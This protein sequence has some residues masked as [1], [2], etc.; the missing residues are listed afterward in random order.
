RRTVT[1]L[2]GLAQLGCDCPCQGQINRLP[3]PDFAKIGRSM[4]NFVGTLLAQGDLAGARELQERALEPRAR[5]AQPLVS[6]TPATS[7]VRPAAPPHS[8]AI[9]RAASMSLTS[10]VRISS[11][12]YD[13]R[14]SMRPATPRYS[15]HVNTLPVVLV[16]CHTGSSNVA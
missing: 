8:L 12:G 4:R 3:E 2:K 6:V 1:H 5:S 10:S 16:G 7:S 14:T 13:A 9:V 15:P 11:C